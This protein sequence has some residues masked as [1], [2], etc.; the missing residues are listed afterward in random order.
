MNVVSRIRFPRT[1]ETSSLYLKC[2]EGACLDSTPEKAEV[3]FT[4]SGVLSLNTYFNSFYET[5]YSKYTKLQSLYYEL[6]LEG[7]FQVSLYRESYNEE[8]RE[9][10]DTKTFEKCQ[11]SEP[12]KIFQ[13]ESWRSTNAGRSYLEITCLSTRGRFTGGW[14][15][16]TQPKLREVSIGIITCTYKKEVYVKETVKVLLKDDFL[17]DKKYKVFIVDNGRTLKQEEFSDPRIQLISNRNVGGSGGF[18]RGIIQALEDDVCTHL[19]FMDD[20]I[21]LESESVYRLFTLYEYA[22]QDLVILGTMLDLYKKY[23][24]YEA[25]AVNGKE[26]TAEGSYR[27]HPFKPAPL[28]YR[29]NL[30]NPS[31][32]NFL[33]VEDKPDYGGFWFFSFSKKTIE[34]IGLLM[35]FFIKADDVEFGLRIK[36]T[37]GD[38]L[39]AFPGIA[40]WHEPFYAKNP[41]WTN[42]YELRNRLIAHSIWGT[43]GYLEAIAFLTKNI[44]QPL[45]VFDYN[46]AEL[47]VEAF[48]NY[49][50]G[51]Q[52]IKN[53]DPEL[54]HSKILTMS[55]KYL[56]SKIRDNPELNKYK[57]TKVSQNKFKKIISLLLLNGHFLPNFLMSDEGIVHWSSPNYTDP[58]HKSFGRK[59]VYIFREVNNYI[60]EN[61]MDKATGRKILNRWL[62]LIIKGSNRWASVNLEWKNAF[63]EFTSVDFWKEYL[64]INSQDEEDKNKILVN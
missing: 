33:L 35:P 14:I 40:V 8:N 52:F 47:R 34:Q 42:Y 18:T 24:L 61:E 60:I 17:Q 30:E 56:N 27:Y 43:L 31:V 4:Q 51:P 22:D 36:K 57:T 48:E 59:R 41:V 26:L 25:G 32:T 15:A 6:K 46:L 19:V 64:Q 45:L 9:L 11:L 44:L 38:V 62:K 63:Q 39:V 28:K 55:K 49:L 37:F 16:T 20:D 29:L 7:D 5:Y 58:W 50:E 21:E 3:A 12:M 53:N 13:P 1:S 23:I 10:I 54:L 2:N